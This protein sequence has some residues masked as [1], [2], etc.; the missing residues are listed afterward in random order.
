MNFYLQPY[1]K[2]RMDFWLAQKQSTANNLVPASTLERAFPFQS[3]NKLNST[4]EKLP[5]T[6]I[7]AYVASPSGH[8]SAKSFASVWI[9]S[10]TFPISLASS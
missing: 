8:P 5:G 4:L 9:L 6:A 2:D 3:Y 10:A 7:M 1:F